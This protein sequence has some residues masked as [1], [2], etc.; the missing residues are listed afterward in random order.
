MRQGRKRLVGPIVVA[1]ALMGPV[2]ARANVFAADGAD[3]RVLVKAAEG[4][5]R[6]YAPIAKVNTLEQTPLDDGRMLRQR[7]TGFMVSPCLLVT[8]V[9]AVFGQTVSPERVAIAGP[10]VEASFATASNPALRIP[11]VPVAWGSR[12][13]G[14]VDD[15]A[16]VRLGECVGAREDIGWFY[17]DGGPERGLAEFELQ[18][19]GW[20]GDLAGLQA[21]VGCRI[22][23]V[24]A[25]HAALNDC[26]NRPGA[27]G[28]PL[29]LERGGVPMVVAFQRGQRNQADT[30]LPAFSSDRANT[31]VTV[32]RL[33]S[34]PDVAALILADRAAL[35]R[36]NPFG[37]LP[38][39]DAEPVQE[40]EPVYNETVATTPAP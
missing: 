32:N 12:A 28:S 11:G 22:Y 21:H 1:L 6:V 17:L 23:S 20:P 15:W 10:R 40:A 18:T 30:V 29:I 27:S 13:N 16:L 35:G 19:A 31:A 36:P 14:G 9:H 3:P 39:P 25:D 33:M 7:G 34:H 4:P 24:T 2:A 8:N 38:V 37:L 5:A 26:A